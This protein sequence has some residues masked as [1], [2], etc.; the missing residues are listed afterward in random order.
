MSIIFVI[1]N[2]FNKKPGRNR[3]KRRFREVWLSGYNRRPGE[4]Q[5]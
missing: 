1:L 2:D 4:R 5:Q 3:G